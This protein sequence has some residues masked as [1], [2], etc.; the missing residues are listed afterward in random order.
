[1]VSQSVGQLVSWRGEKR[2]EGEWW[3]VSHQPSRDLL[4]LLSLHSFSLF[5]PSSFLSTSSSSPNNN[6]YSTRLSYIGVEGPGGGYRLTTPLYREREEPL[7]STNTDPSLGPLAGVRICL[8]IPDL[9]L[10]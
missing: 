6:T 8:V 7:I 2:D 4:C 10:V 3:S 9:D 5:L 1:M